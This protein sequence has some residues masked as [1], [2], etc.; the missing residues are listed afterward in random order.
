MRRLSFL[1]L[2]LPVLVAGKCGGGDGGGSGPLVVDLPTSDPRCVALADIGGFPPGY[3]FVPDPGG[4]PAPMRA[5]AATSARSNLIPLAIEKIPFE[6]PPGSAPLQL[7]ADS[8]GDGNLEFFKSI[9]GVVVLSSKLAL[10]SVSGSL[11]GVVFVDPLGVSLRDVLVSVPAG[12][13][14]AAFTAFPGL[15]AP[16][17]SRA[18]TG[19]TSTACIDAGVDA[20]DSRGVRLED[21]VAPVFQCDGPGTFPASFT[22]AAAVVGNRLFVAMS[23]L[24]V[25]AGQADSQFLP[26]VVVVYDFDSSVDP[27]AVGPTLDTADGRSYLVTSGFNPTGLTGFAAGGRDFLLVSHTGAIG[28]RADDPNTDALESGAVAITDGL[29][30]VIDVEALELVATIP[31]LGANPA[32]DGLAIDP[33]GRVALFGDVNARRLYGIDLDVL[34]SIGPAGSGGPPEVLDAA[35]VFDGTNPLE[36]PALPGGAPLVTCP[37][38]IEGVAFNAAGDAAYALDT[39]DG[40]VSALDVDLS[41]AP[42]TAELRDRIVFSTLSPATAPVRVDTLGRLRRPSSLRVRPGVPGVD[43]AG[44]DVFFMLGEPEG[45]LCGVR[46]DSP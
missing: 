12:F 26:G 22:S 16:G 4:A 40:T 31:L 41:G 7:P 21:G 14:P 42:S 6:V 44:P 32:F 3:D 37:G 19:I 34:A 20:L 5:L 43:Y 29:I 2:I 25:D 24:G 23:N 15:P 36:L 45:F 18:Q 9:A 13:D 17:E 30:D 35:I 11:E 33:T 27:I 10:V 39:C 1:L 46:I 38:Q 28:I 8:D